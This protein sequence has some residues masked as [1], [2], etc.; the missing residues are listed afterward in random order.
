[1]SATL[2]GRTEWSASQDEE[3]YRTYT[4]KFRVVTNDPD[5]GPL[6]VGTCPGLP[7]IFTYWQ[8]G[9]ESDGYAHCSPEL[10]IEQ[11]NRGPDPETNWIVTYKYTTKPAGGEPKRFENP[12]LEP[13]TISG[14][15][16]RY[17]KKCLV[18]RHGRWIR[19]TA[20]EIYP[21]SDLDFDDARP[22]VAVGVNTAYNLIPLITP[23]MN[24]VNDAP[25][26]GCPKRTV[27]LSAAQWERKYYTPNQMM[28]VFYYHTV[29]E[30][31]IDFDTHDKRLPD[32]GTMCLHQSF[33][34]QTDAQKDSARQS[35]ANIVR[36]TTIRQGFPAKVF[37]DGHGCPL[38][39]MDIIVKADQGKDQPIS[40][41]V[42]TE[43]PTILRFQ[44][45]QH[46]NFFMLGPWFPA[47]L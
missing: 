8:F 15:Y 29:L 3:G 16:A 42:P 11:V 5:D 30:F 33:W 21:S 39:G 23:M 19:N 2:R 7:S 6:V 34:T 27:Q 26:W 1:M 22:T 17:S 28:Y 14:S 32:Y 43:P 35:L 41:I 9:N 45:Y 37:L 13:I 20:Q 18:D 12:L 4:I 36:Y 24:G 10:Q 44:K 46:C 40:D 25:L 38:S 47:T 31:T